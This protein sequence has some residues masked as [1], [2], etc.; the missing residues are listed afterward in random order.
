MNE[1][2]QMINGTWHVF[3]GFR[4]KDLEVGEP[5]TRAQVRSRKADVIEKF[6]KDCEE[7]SRT[8]FNPAQ[9]HGM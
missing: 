4:I 1:K 7:H 6:R 8:H 2:I 9:F 3:C 5:T